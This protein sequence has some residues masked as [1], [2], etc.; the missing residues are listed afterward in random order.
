MST[1]PT[2]PTGSILSTAVASSFTGYSATLAKVTG[3][4]GAPAVWVSPREAYSDTARSTPAVDGGT[5]RAMRDISGNGRDSFSEGTTADPNYVLAS[6][7]P[8]AGIDYSF[9]TTN[10][11][12]VQNLWGAAGFSAGYTYFAVGS[13]S[14]YQTG[15][16]GIIMNPSDNFSFLGI[17]APTV[18]IVGTTNNRQS[19]FAH[20]TNDLNGVYMLQWDGITQTFGLNGCYNTVASAGTLPTT[21]GAFD[22]SIGGMLGSAGNQWTNGKVGDVLVYPGILTNLQCLQI[23]S[24]LNDNAQ[25]C[26]PAYIMTGDSI[27]SGLNL[28]APSEQNW[29]NQLMKTLGLDSSNSYQ[30]N[31]AVAGWTLAQM[32]TWAQVFINGPGYVS[33]GRGSAPNFPIIFGGTNS[34]SA[35]AGNDNLSAAASF[36]QFQTLCGLWKSSTSQKL[37]VCTC[38]PRDATNAG[39]AFEGRRQAFNTLMRNA[40]GTGLFDGLID[41]AADP[42][43]QIGALGTS[44]YQ[45]DNIHPSEQGAAIL[46]EIAAPILASFSAGIIVKPVNKTPALSNSRVTGAGTAYSLTTSLAAVVFGT[47]SPSLSLPAGTYLLVGGLSFSGGTTGDAVQGQLLNS[48]G[49]AAIG[50]VHQDTVNLAV[51]TDVADMVM[52]DTVTLSVQSTVTMQAANATGARG[53]VIAANS[54]LVAVRIG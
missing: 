21:N 7:G 2:Q 25:V 23:S 16:D 24:I 34:M 43:W 48:T 27:S 45:G 37:I 46:A 20:D 49:A 38:I 50:V 9:R 44:I 13:C 30:G 36:L 6:I 42:R 40:V 28:P 22:L 26:K 5:V 31:Q 10:C 3:V 4:A 1:I 52:I 51:G 8:N 12:M 14:G 32:I 17:D 54:Y 33:P 19:K 11:Q 47:T 39:A 29:F 53:T 15:H 18:S 41:F 35:A